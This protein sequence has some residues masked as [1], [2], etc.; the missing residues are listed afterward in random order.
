M[1]R[2]SIGPI[3]QRRRDDGDDLPSY[4]FDGG[5]LLMLPPSWLP[6]ILAP[7]PNCDDAN[8]TRRI[9][10]PPP[11]VVVIVIIAIVIGMQRRRSL[12]VV[13]VVINI[14]GV[15]VD[16]N[17]NEAGRGRSSRLGSRLHDQGWRQRSR[18][19]Q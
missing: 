19:R 12:I 6:L 5:D 2:P 9:P 1:F 15:D 17:A 18:R 10:T 3:A 16:A 7:M 4:F 8:P 14:G 11:V 13:V